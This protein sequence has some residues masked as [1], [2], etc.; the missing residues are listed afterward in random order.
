L[1]FGSERSGGYGGFDIWMSVKSDQ[2]WGEPINLGPGVNT[3]AD[4]NRPFLTA[5]GAAL[6]FDSTTRSGLYYPGPAVFRSERQTDGTWDTAQEI[7]SQFAGE[8]ILSPDG[9]TLYFVHHYFDKD[10]SQMLE[11]DIYVS[12]KT[13][14]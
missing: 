2:G 9:N 11:A 13:I 5:D 10:L 8:P 12:H 6:W 14:P 1:Y 3:A 7:V 4:E